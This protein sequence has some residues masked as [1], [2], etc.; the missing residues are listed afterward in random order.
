MLQASR[1]LGLRGLEELCLKRLG[2]FK[3]RVRTGAI[4]WAE[5]A[6][7]RVEAA[8]G[9][10]KGLVQPNPDPLV[11]TKGMVGEISSVEGR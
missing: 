3:S 9:G 10:A 1:D 7:G 4:G 11:W 6:A 5:V 2:E 8:T